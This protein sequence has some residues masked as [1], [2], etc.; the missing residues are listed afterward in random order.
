MPKKYVSRCERNWVLDSESGKEGNLL[1]VAELGD[2]LAKV[3]TDFGKLFQRIGAVRLY[4]RLDILKEEVVDGRSRVRRLE[5]RVK[6]TGLILIS[7]SRYWGC[8]VGRKS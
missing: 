5:E 7:F 8:E 1:V 6:P 2:V 4:E 3:R